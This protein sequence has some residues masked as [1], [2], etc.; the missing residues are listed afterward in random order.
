MLGFTI[1]K[2]ASV[3][4]SIKPVRSGHYAYL[5]GRKKNE[6]YLLGII[7]PFLMCF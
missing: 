2:S 6:Y 7:L 4:W 1:I 5:P 3:T